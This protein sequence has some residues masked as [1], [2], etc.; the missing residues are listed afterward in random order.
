L[1]KTR[2]GSYIVGLPAMPEVEP[3]SPKLTCSFVRAGESHPRCNGRVTAQG[4]ARHPPPGFSA[5]KVAIEASKRSTSP[6]VRAEA[7]AHAPTRQLIMR[8]F[9]AKVLR[10]SQRGAAHAGCDSNQLVRS[11]QPCRPRFP[12]AMRPTILLSRTAYT[13]PTC[14]TRIPK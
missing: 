14:R 5:T 3:L 8:S 9:F 6:G 11:T 13:A 4:H 2:D 7:A 1:K 10:S 12:L